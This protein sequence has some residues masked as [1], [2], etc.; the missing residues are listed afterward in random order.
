MGYFARGGCRNNTSCRRKR[1]SHEVKKKK[2]IF[3]TQLFISPNPSCLLLHSH[4]LPILQPGRLSLPLS[5][6]LPLHSCMKKKG[7]KSVSALNA[8][9]HTYKHTKLNP[10]NQWAKPSIYLSSWVHHQLQLKPLAC[11]INGFAG[12]SCRL[13]M[14]PPSC[15]NHRASEIQLPH[16]CLGRWAICGKAGRIPLCILFPHRRH[17]IE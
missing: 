10:D 6:S 4:L 13:N 3:L 8:H 9:T 17:I 7:E 15:R 2:P 5:L 12:S 11:L 16:R 1:E 14:V